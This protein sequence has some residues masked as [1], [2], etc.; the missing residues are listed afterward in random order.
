LSDRNAICFSSFVSLL[1]ALTVSTRALL[2]PLLTT[3]TPSSHPFSPSTTPAPALFRPLSTM[4]ISKLLYGLSFLLGEPRDEYDTSSDDEAAKKTAKKAQKRRPKTHTHNASSS[5]VIHTDEASGFTMI[6]SASSI[7]KEKEQEAHALKKRPHKRQPSNASSSS[8]LSGGDQPRDRHGDQGFEICSCHF[9]EMPISAFSRHYMGLS[10]RGQS[11]YMHPA[12]IGLDSCPTI[13]DFELASLKQ[14]FPTQ[15]N[16]LPSELL[17]SG[18]WQ[19]ITKFCSVSRFPIPDGVSFYF[20]SHDTKPSGNAYRILPSV[21]G[22]APTTTIAAPHEAQLNQVKEK[23]A[24]A[25]KVLPQVLFTSPN[26]WSFCNKFCYFSDSAINENKDVFYACT[27]GPGEEVVRPSGQQYAAGKQLY[28]I[29]GGSTGQ[30]IEA[31]FDA[32][33]KPEDISTVEREFQLGRQDFEDLRMCHSQKMAALP[34][35]LTLT[36]FGLH[37]WRKVEPPAYTRAREA[38]IHRIEQSQRAA[39][40][41]AAATAKAIVDLQKKEGERKRRD[42]Q[43]HE[44]AIQRLTAFARK[45]SGVESEVKRRGDAE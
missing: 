38:A 44:A 17:D 16:K 29:Y 3:C 14:S 2:L 4:L 43:A 39:K 15:Y 7:R 12:A 31:L 11:F 34:A 8:N 10:A 35:A 6:Q 27:L 45:R 40:D 42:A 37:R 22:M 41:L 25:A 9:S 23:Y 28:L 5:S 20:S 18:A 32:A 13:G 19:R 26:Q 24:S 36:G 21:F 30:S 33:M 1:C